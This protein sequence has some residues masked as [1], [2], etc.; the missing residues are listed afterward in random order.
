MKSASVGCGYW[1]APSHPYSEDR[2]LCSVLQLFGLGPSTL[3]CPVQDPLYISIPY[4][5]TMFT[6]I[7]HMCLCVIII[8]L[9]S[10]S[11][12]NKQTTYVLTDFF[13]TAGAHAV[14]S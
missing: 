10:D 1:L 6:H 4:N 8:S 12:Y 11:D 9:H 14:Y 7:L 5:L 2:A 13:S 3:H